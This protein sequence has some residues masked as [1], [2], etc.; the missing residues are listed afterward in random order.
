MPAKPAV[1]F[2]HGAGHGPHGLA[3]AGALV[4]L[5]RPFRAGARSAGAWPLGR[6]GARLGRR[7]GGVG[8]PRCSDAAGVRKRRARRSLHGRR[9]RAGG[10]RG[11][12]RARVPRVALLGTAA[13]IPVHRDLLAAAREQP[14]TRLPHDDGLGVRRARQDGRQSRARPVD[15]RRPLALFARN[16]PG[17]LHT[18]LAACNAWK[19]GAEAARK[20]ALPGPRRLAANDIMTPPKAGRE[21]A[22]LIPAA[23]LS[24]SRAADT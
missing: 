11:D 21:L 13:A 15:D 14:D 4:R 24:P 10:R 2:L 17:V 6:A 5:A 12:G 3:A 20:R 16:Q 1:V 19:T 23:A 7:D 18:D 9:H 22:G 8:R